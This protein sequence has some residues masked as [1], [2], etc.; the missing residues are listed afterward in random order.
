V[1][2]P[3]TSFGGVHSSWERRARWSSESAPHSLI[4]L[5]VG[6]EAEPELWSDLERALATP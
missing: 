3:A 1:V 2:R 4:R 6:I 5:S